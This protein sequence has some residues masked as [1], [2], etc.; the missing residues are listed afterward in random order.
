MT[1][2]YFITIA[3]TTHYFSFVRI[4]NLNF[5][6]KCHVNI[7]WP[8][9]SGQSNFFFLGHL[10]SNPASQCS[11]LPINTSLLPY[12]HCY[13]LLPITTKV[14]HIDAVDIIFSLC[15]YTIL[16]ICTKLLVQKYMCHG[17]VVSGAGGSLAT[18]EPDSPGSYPSLRSD[19]MLSLMSYSVDGVLPL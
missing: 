15:I 5:H 3:I 14:P 12:C 13:P 11:L 4:Q 18:Y 7:V 1:H 16:C 6:A 9:P 2:Y 19:S 10:G 17:S 8:W